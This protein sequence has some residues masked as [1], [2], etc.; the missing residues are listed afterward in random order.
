MIKD[1][2]IYAAHIWNRNVTH[3]KEKKEQIAT[4]KLRYIRCLSVL[5]FQSNNP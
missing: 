5:S 3:Y 2:V 1:A 4:L